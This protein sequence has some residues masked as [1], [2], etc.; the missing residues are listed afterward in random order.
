LN[1]NYFIFIHKAHS[2]GIALMMTPTGGFTNII[3]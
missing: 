1:A 2:V 3:N